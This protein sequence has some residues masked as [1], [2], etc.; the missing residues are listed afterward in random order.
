MRT[1]WLAESSQEALIDIVTKF[2]VPGIVFLLT[3]ASGVWLSR[4]GKP[5][6]VAVFNV[7]KLIALAAVVLAAIQV[8]SALQ[9]VEAQFVLIALIGLVVLAVIVLFTTGALMSMNK[10]AYIMLLTIHNVAPFV[11]VIAMGLAIDLLGRGT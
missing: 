11:A 4:A 10:P 6:N 8:R 3:L 2:I 7:H 5:L 9:N 1:M